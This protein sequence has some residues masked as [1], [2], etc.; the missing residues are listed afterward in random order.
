MKPP[1]LTQL[2]YLVLTSI[3]GKERSGKELRARLLNEGY[4]K[5]LPAFYQLMSRLE[6][7]G[8]VR[9]KNYEITVDGI[10]I[11]ERRY[12]LTSRGLKTASDV[13]QFVL[14]NW[15]NLSEAGSIT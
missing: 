11:K 2:Q 1:T 13:H 8:L 15:E 7:A 5:S 4:Q 6:D 9:G 3:G 10:S 12:I 14:R